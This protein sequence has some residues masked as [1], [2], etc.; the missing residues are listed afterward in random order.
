MDKAP[1][2]TFEAVYG[3]DKTPLKLGNIEI[4]CYV[5]NDGTR[6]FSGRGIQKAIGANTN[7]SGTWLS[8]F[9]NSSTITDYIDPGVL[10]KFNNPLKFKRP[11]ASGSQS[12]TN[13]YEA[14]LLIDLCDSVIEASKSRDVDP[15]L[16]MSA[17]VIIRSVAKVGIIAL[18][19]EVTGYNKDKNRAKDELQKFLA[20]VIRIEA[21]KWVRRFDDSFFEMIYKMKGWT[22]NYTKKHPGVVGTWINDIVYQRLGPMVLAELREKNPKTE[23]GGRKSK[24]HQYLSDD[25]GVPMLK[26]HLVGLEALA[27]ASNYNWSAFMGMV[28]RVYPKQYQQLSLMFD[29]SGIDDENTTDFDNNLKQALNFNPKK[30]KNNDDSESEPVN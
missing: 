5:L 1:I 3:S 22:W 2:K 29:E 25:Y 4:P 10:D 15:K 18:V 16:L 26:N 6:V 14:T 24:H 30:D 13:G 9:V 27:K 19:D 12:E 21:A 28:D 11:N 20:Q 17:E 8:K 7:A 23:K